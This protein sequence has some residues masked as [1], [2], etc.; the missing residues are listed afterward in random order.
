ML[1]AHYRRT[2]RGCCIARR[3]T[4][5]VSLYGGSNVLSLDVGNDE[6]PEILA[7]CVEQFMNLLI[8]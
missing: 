4:S 2:K 6:S 1:V 8:V 5:T 3:R 7:A